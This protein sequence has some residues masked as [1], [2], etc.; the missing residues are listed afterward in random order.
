VHYASEEVK[1]LNE[2]INGIDNKRAAVVMLS[3]QTSF[4]CK[5]AISAFEEHYHTIVMLTTRF[6]FGFHKPQGFL[7]FGKFKPP[8]VKVFIEW[9]GAFDRRIGAD[10]YEVDMEKGGLLFNIGAAYSRWATVVMQEGNVPQA[11]KYFLKSAEVFKH[12]RDQ[13]WTNA[14]AA[15]SCDFS[16]PVLTFLCDLMQAQA[17]A[18]FF[19]KATS[20]N[21]SPALVARLAAGASQLYQTAHGHVEAKECKT[22]FAKS[23]YPWANHAF[24]Q[25]LCFNASAQF[26]QAKVRLAEGKYGI[27]VA[28]L[29]K[30]K[31]YV[32]EAKRFK[33][34]LFAHL[35]ENYAQLQRTI[36][37]AEKTASR[38]NDTVY[39]AFVP[40]ED[41][42]EAI[43]PHVAVKTQDYVPPSSFPGLAPFD[44]LVPAEVLT[45]AAL[46][47]Q[48]LQGMLEEQ[49][50]KMNED[51]DY[52]KMHLASLNLPAAIE[53]M[54]TGGLPDETWRQ[55]A[56]VQ[57]KGGFECLVKL[58]ASVASARQQAVDL[59]QEVKAALAKEKDEDEEMR[60]NF[61]HRWNRRSSAEITAP[62]QQELDEISNFLAAALTADNKV[63][64]QMVESEHL[65]NALLRDR[66]EITR[67][68]PAVEASQDTKS[69]EVVALT[70]LLNN[71][72]A[73]LTKRERAVQLVT[74]RIGETNSKQLVLV[75]IK[76]LPAEAIAEAQLAKY[77]NARAVLDKLSAGQRDLLE[78]ITRGHEAFQRTRSS[79]PAL[80]ARENVLQ[81]L[82]NGVNMFNKLFSHSQEGLKF[83]VDL[84]SRKI[85]PVKGNVTD[86][87]MARSMEKQMIL[88]QLT[89]QLGS[90]NALNNNGSGVMPAHNPNLNSPQGGTNGMY[91]FS[92][93]NMASAPVA[94]APPQFNAGYQAPMQQGYNRPPP[95]Q[96]NQ[97]YQPPN[98]FTQPQ[99]Y[100]QPN[101][102]AYPGQPAPQQQPLTQHPGFGGQGAPPSSGPSPQDQWSCPACTFVNHNDHGVCQI[103]NTRKP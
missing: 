75:E 33:K 8:T 70:E 100:Q 31:G 88:E 13:T 53:A 71:L 86:F 18:C 87:L 22:A 46:V 62:I 26:W 61:S 68:L 52:A 84:I 98:Q 79:N 47:D 44:D 89:N 28:H 42:M 1:R 56:E 43:A 25:H 19:E 91:Q 81:S 10:G 29:R 2:T 96:F 93:G 15:K 11:S 60:R 12:L 4:D 80:A 50:K 72:S 64:T 9:Y 38:D 57:F 73:A 76:R 94:S 54:D 55:V 82:N 21:M 36:E 102:Y 40:R 6:T 83:Y 41:A 74:K 49:K 90:M 5:E 78:Q 51:C 39:S 99:S 48:K 95:P 59:F 14:L 23:G 58:Q 97:Q 101:Q 27:Q 20:A 103:C 77:A 16:P 65:I 69:A 67:A 24:F 35:L 92:S 37:A 63:G 45:G 66:Q 30:A 85:E 32:E 3:A 17:Q 34:G 7:S